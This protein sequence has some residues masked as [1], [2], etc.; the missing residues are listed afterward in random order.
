[1][2]RFNFL[3]LMMLLLNV[4]SLEVPQLQ[5]LS[6]WLLRMTSA[7]Y[8]L[9]RYNKMC[10]KQFKCRGSIF[11]VMYCCI[12]S[13]LWLCMIQLY[14][15]WYQ[16]YFYYCSIYQHYIWWWKG[17]KGF[18]SNTLLLEEHYNC[19]LRTCLLSSNYHRIS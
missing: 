9:W 1:M 8:W 10:F 12:V 6:K 15:I 5:S 13:K 7:V 11:D 17:Y 19:I 2:S 14:H 18:I 16:L 4:S 3:F